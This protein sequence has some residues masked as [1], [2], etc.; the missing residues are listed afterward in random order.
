[1]LK[2]FE[3]C[4]FIACFRSW[5]S[6]S[7]NILIFHDKLHRSQMSRH[8]FLEKSLGYKFIAKAVSYDEEMPCVPFTPYLTR[9]AKVINSF[10]RVFYR[11][12]SDANTVC[13]LRVYRVWKG[14]AAEKASPRCR[15]SWPVKFYQDIR[16]HTRVADLGIVHAAI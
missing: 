6:F 3:E 2:L 7:V 14:K 4:D 11:A 12:T 13:Q 15:C 8:I 5:S 10:V 1:M 9:R 16:I